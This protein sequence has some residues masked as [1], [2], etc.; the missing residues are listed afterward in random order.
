MNTFLL[1]AGHFIVI[2]DSGNDMNFQHILDLMNHLLMRYNDI[3][4]NNLPK[5]KTLTIK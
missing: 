2:Q 4:V 3:G 5:A 1:A